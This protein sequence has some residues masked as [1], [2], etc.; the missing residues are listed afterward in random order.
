MQENSN[1]ESENL[2]TETKTATT[3][4][5]RDMYTQPLW[6]PKATLAG[7]NGDKSL[8]ME[9]ATLFESESKKQTT[10]LNA[11][12]TT[13]N[14]KKIKS[15]AHMIKGT[16]GHFYAKHMSHLATQIEKAASSN[17]H[18]QCVQLNKLLQYEMGQLRVAL[19]KIA[20]Q[21]TIDNTD[22]LM[23]FGHQ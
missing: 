22:T 3:D 4:T 1:Q 5:Y 2:M 9:L 20:T 12:I 17:D 8:F 21:E 14:N 15:T 16:A 6:D 18:H 13:H 10:T 23:E 11:A 7:L 19:R